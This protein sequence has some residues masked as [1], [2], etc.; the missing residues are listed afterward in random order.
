[1]MNLEKILRQLYL[2]ERRPEETTDE[3]LV[4]TR[5]G[6][7]V[8]LHWFLAERHRINGRI[9]AVDAVKHVITLEAAESPVS[10]ECYPGQ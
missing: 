2:L 5:E 3:E 7:T 10:I 4:V 9:V 8:V 1:M 6:S